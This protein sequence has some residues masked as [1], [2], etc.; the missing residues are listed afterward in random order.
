VT[1]MK[2]DVR[3]QKIRDRIQ[4]VLARISASPGVPPPLP[5]PHFPRPDCVIRSCPICGRPHI[6]QEFARG[7]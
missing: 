7:G 4:E 5:S 1:R 3:Q 2:E 6:G